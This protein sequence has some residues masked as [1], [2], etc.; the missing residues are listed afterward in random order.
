M[1]LL[2]VKEI[3]KAQ[4]FEQIKVVVTTKP[5][6]QINLDRIACRHSRVSTQNSV[7]IAASISCIC[8]N[9]RLVETLLEWWSGSTLSSVNYLR[10]TSKFLLTYQSV[11]LHI[12]TLS[13]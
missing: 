3:Y 1:L 10:A 9:T 8:T 4:G 13:I 6:V 5:A 7:G 2:K 11:S 12:Y